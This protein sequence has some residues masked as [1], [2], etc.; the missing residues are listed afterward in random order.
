MGFDTSILRKWDI[1]GIYKEQITKEVAI[2]VGFS[3][4]R[5]LKENNKHICIIGRDNRFGG[6]VLKEGLTYG[7]TESG[8][9]VIDYG[10]ITT[11]MLNF[12]CH[13]N[14]N[15]YGIM[16]TA[17]HNPKCDNGFKL[18]GEDCLHLKTDKLTYFYEIMK[19]EERI[20]GDK[21]GKVTKKNIKDEYINDLV[22][23]INLP[24]KTKVVVDCG[25][26]TASIIIKDVYDK[27]NCDVTYLYCESDPNFPNHHPDPNVFENLTDLRKMVVHTKSDLGIAY[28]GDADRVGIVD[29]LGNII[30]TDKLMSIYSKNILK[31][32][33]NKNIIIDVKCSKALE[34]YIKNCGGNPIMVCNGSSYI[35]SFVHDYPAIFGGEY[36]GHVF[37]NDKHYGYDDGIYAGLRLQEII[38]EENKSANML[39]ED[40]PKLVSTPEIKVHCDDNIKF[41]IVDKVLEYCKEKKYD[42]LDIDGVRVKFDDG[43]ALIRC[44]NTGPN[45]TLRFESTTKEK[46]DKMQTEFMTLVDELIKK[47]NSN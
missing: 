9:D 20:L 38:I 18:F 46:T 22:S 36:S 10:L 41:G 39:Y 6:K 33:D 23:K 37:F 7:L 31:K 19:K 21:K 16:I 32:S 40:Y 44:S 11:P 12:A 1:R 35:E 4:G 25:N 17:S 45:L 29:N 8:I 28:D 15:A 26:G 47:A 34:D 27:L 24:K 3:F 2:N 13:K 30:E 43:W 5:F 42:Y 14:D